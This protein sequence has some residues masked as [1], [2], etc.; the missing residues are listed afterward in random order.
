MFSPRLTLWLDHNHPA[1]WTG[2][3]LATALF[4]G[5]VLTALWADRRAGPAPVAVESRWRV[6]LV[7]LLLLAAWRWPLWFNPANFNPDESQI[8][9]GAQALTHD[10]VFWRSVDG[11]TAGPLNFYVLLW[12]K[13]A[14][15]PVNF[16]T[17]RLTGLLLIW[18]ALLSSYGILRIFQA[19]GPAR[20]ALVPVAL[21][22]A[23]VTQDDFV[24][25]STEHLPLFLFA[26][27]T[28]LLV[29]RQCTGAG[30]SWA[31]WAGGAGLGLLPWAKLQSIPLGA[32][33]VAWL[34]FA[35]WRDA[36][37]P[38]AEKRRRSRDLL[39]AGLAPSLLF[40]G[41]I[42]ACGVWPF[43]LQGYI[44]QNFHY[45]A[46]DNTLTYLWHT[47][48]RSLNLTWHFQV[49]LGGP[50]LVA[51]AGSLLYRPLKLPYRAL[52]SLGF[53]LFLAALVAVIAPRR[54]FAHYLLFL[55]LPL[56]FWS[57][58]VIGDLWNRLARPGARLGLVSVCLLLGGV[59]P[60]ALRFSQPVPG[61]I[62]RLEESRTHPL[63]AA[64]NILRAYARPGDRLGI[65]GWMCDLNVETGLPQATR[66]GNSFLCIQPSPQFDYYRQLYLADL[67]R[68]RP[69][70]FVDAVGPTADFFQD[71]VHEAHENFPALAAYIRANYTE[72]IDLEYARI[73]VRHDRA[74]AARI[75]VAQLHALAAA[76]RRV[77]GRVSPEPVSIAQPHLQ[78]NVI[79]GHVV[80]MMLPRAELAWPLQG[81]E[82]E[83]YFECGYDPRAYL[84]G[85]S[86]GTL[87]TA[88]LA[89][90][91]G[92]VFPI[93]SRLLDPGHKVTDRGLVRD[94]F[95]LP[96]VPAG[97]RLI[98][99]TTPGPE[100]NAV[101]D[102]AYLASAAFDHSPLYSHGQFPGFN[103][104]PDSVI[105]DV[106][107][108]MTED[109]RIVL[110]LHAPAS[111]VFRLH[112][113]ER[114]VA[115]DF[116]FR[117]GAYGDGGNTDGAGYSV[118]LRR[119]GLPDAKLL[120]RLLQPVSQPA[121]RGN[122]HVD[123][124]LPEE[125]GAGA[126]LVLAIDPGPYGSHSWDWTYVANLK[127]K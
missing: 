18:G 98:L 42:A 37:R 13:L 107:Y 57:G 104:L 90:P 56:L 120:Q 4:A 66:Q 124:L 14:G 39:L 99:R 52:W 84:E 23:M 123:L 86:N 127:I 69:A 105:N 7:L 30:G 29:R 117:T 113:G 88:E 5:W 22:L 10:P 106:A 91:S 67:Q 71:R 85:T 125:A 122:Q 82:R 12:V 15:A 8:I 35:L 44:L 109:T 9:A 19:R 45:V 47:T 97:T 74:D 24:H 28:F 126:E 20:L 53:I 93:Y 116:G 87:F 100:E 75:D 76:G 121:D 46:T 26:G 33:V 38:A 50:L 58:A 81:T 63:T 25:Y 77:R 1:Y 40:L 96:P 103:R 64:G 36:S 114:S 51:V 95:P 94:H 80:R 101:W 11:S 89:T 78:Q 112:G 72:L 21:F 2:A 34:G 119:A 110:A 61:M 6:A 73:Y 41:L 31:W 3:G 32:A 43:F 48:S 79:G 49:C 54:P 102:W 27:S 60:L 17:A 16:I 108:V 59:L 118:A 68:N 70:L 83:F 115:F 55:V 111:L 65:W 62:D 92:A